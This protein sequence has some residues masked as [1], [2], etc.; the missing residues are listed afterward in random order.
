M[1]LR[2]QLAA[3]DPMS[4][5]IGAVARLTDTTERLRAEPITHVPFDPCLGM[6]QDDERI[7]IGVSEQHAPSPPG[8][9]ATVRNHMPGDI[10]SQRLTDTRSEVIQRNGQTLK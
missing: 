8:G 1:R 5:I 7:A 2:F 10:R 4:A 3:S 6:R 9:R